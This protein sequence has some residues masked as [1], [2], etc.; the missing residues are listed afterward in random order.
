MEPLQLAMTVHLDRVGAFHQDAIARARR[1]ALRRMR[2]FGSLPTVEPR[3]QSRS[4]TLRLT[5]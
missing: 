2:R 1:A 3:P 4:T 5:Q